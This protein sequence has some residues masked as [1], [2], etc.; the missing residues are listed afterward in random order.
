MA[1]QQHRNCI[2]VVRAK[3]CYM[4]EER[5]AFEATLEGDTKLVVL[6][7]HEQLFVSMFAIVAVTKTTFGNQLF[8]QISH[9][10]V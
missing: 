6:S 8:I 2:V 1:N 10:N 5:A 7:A 3:P 4:Q 9:V